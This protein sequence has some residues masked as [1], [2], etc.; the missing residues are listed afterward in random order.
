MVIIWITRPKK[1]YP[2]VIEEN[3]VVRENINQELINS[4]ISYEGQ[5]IKIIENV[6]YSD[7]KYAKKRIRK[8]PWREKWKLILT[9]K[10]I[11]FLGKKIFFNSIF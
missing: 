7:P 1:L 11:V 6:G 5:L 8:W 3:E 4:G 9:N 10:E 2:E